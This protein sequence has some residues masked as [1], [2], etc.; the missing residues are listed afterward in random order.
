ML[1]RRIISCI[2]LPAYLSACFKTWEVQQASPEQVIETEQ[3]SQIRVLTK[4]GAEIILDKPRVSGDN[5]IGFV[6]DLTSFGSIYAAPDTLAVVEIPLAEISHV[7]VQTTDSGKSVAAGLLVVTAL[8]VVA[9][10]AECSSNNDEG[11]TV[12]CRH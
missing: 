10:V 5:L 4:D 12:C 2:L 6:R 1:A 9:V 11:I 8:L 3:P 7:A